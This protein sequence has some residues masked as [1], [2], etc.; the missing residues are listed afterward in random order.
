MKKSFLSDVKWI[1]SEEMNVAIGVEDGLPS[2]DAADIVYAKLKSGETLPLHFHNRPTS[3]GY[4]A[5]FFF[6]GADISII[7]KDSK[8]EKIKS[9]LPFHLTFGDQELHGLINDSERD[10]VFEVL[11]APKHV[12]GE[13]VLV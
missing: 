5:F 3:D 1:F 12:E 7:L 4:E 11:C 6:Q 13:E 2:N 9:D 8:V 10:L